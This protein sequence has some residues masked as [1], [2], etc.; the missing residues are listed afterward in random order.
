MSIGE[1]IITKNVNSIIEDLKEIYSNYRIFYRNDFKIDDAKEVINE[2]YISSATQKVIIIAGEK[3]NIYA[4][5]ALLKLL[6]EPP[7][8]IKFILIAKSKNT[9]LPT[10]K[11]R[12]TL[13]NKKGKTSH[14]ILDI[15]LNSITI[16]DIVNYV[17]LLHS[18]NK[19]EVK[20][21]IQSLLFSINAFKINLNANELDYFNRAIEQNEN[22]CSAK[23]I[24]L[25]LL[26]MI[27][28][29]ISK[30]NKYKITNNG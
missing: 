27:F 28:K 29:H 4:Q 13:T 22:Y 12:M 17:N 6:E 15:N 2:S 20:E 25:E 8:N 26:L 23:Y 18:Y 16:G 1:I 11:S 21:N 14:K 10:I 30:N 24:F 5:N 7:N 9:I 3:F 19:E